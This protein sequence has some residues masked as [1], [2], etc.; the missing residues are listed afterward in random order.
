MLFNFI[1]IRSNQAKESFFDPKVGLGRGAIGPDAIFNGNAA[2]EV[3]AKGSIDAPLLRCDVAVD[4]GYIFFV[5]FP[6][7]PNA[8]KIAG[9]SR[10]FGNDH[11][12]GGF[13]IQAV[14]EV[15]CIRM[16]DTRCRMR[17]VHLPRG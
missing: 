14:D 3:F 1:V 17:D 12:A 16:P 11:E 15:G 7:F 6:G 5:D 13:A 2:V 8:A 10:V 4:D 9:C